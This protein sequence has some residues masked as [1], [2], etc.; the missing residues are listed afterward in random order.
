[1]SFLVDEKYNKT[2]NVNPGLINPGL[3]IKGVLPQ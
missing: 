2:V 1:M 3:L